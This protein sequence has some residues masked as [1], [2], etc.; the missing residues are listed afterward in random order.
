M[1]RFVYSKPV[2]G[3]HCD[4]KRRIPFPLRALSRMFFNVF[5]VS[6]E[7]FQSKFGTFQKYLILSG[8]NFKIAPHLGREVKFRPHSVVGPL[9][10]LVK[11]FC[12]RYYFGKY[13]VK[14]NSVSKPA[15]AA[16]KTD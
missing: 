7:I 5:P 10:Y 16:S 11:T 15:T 2:S 14:A 8:I 9:V 12:I 1:L 4:L 6:L 3:S 13:C